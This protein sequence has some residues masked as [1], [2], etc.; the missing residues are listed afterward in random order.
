VLPVVH[1]VVGD[2]RLSVAT[3]ALAVLLAVVAGTATARRRVGPPAGAVLLA[4]LLACALVAGA[5]LAGA[6]GLARLLH[7]P[8]PG[9]LLSIG[10]IAVGLV[11]LPVAA[12]V[13]GI[14]AARLADGVVPGALVAFAAGRV[15]CFLAGCCVGV[16]TGLPWGVVFPEAGPLP[17]H[18]LPLYE[19]AAQLAVVATLAGRASVPGRVAATGCVRWGLARA[20]LELLRDPAA[21]DVLLGP[22]SVA[23]GAALAVAAAA[24]ATRR[25]LRP[26][27][28]IDYASPLEEPRS[29]PTRSR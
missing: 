2:V 18:P 1:V 11:M 27:A 21:R 16:P 3:H 28:A 19:A 8:T 29:W 15:G 25:R 12:R 22:L 13:A 4:V 20:A 24:A 10:G 23:Q 9:G 5:G 14:G 26:A 7:G 17:R 6:R